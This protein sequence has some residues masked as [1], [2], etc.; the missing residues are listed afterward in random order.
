MI[1]VEKQEKFLRGQG[2][3][4]MRQ[5]EKIKSE[6]GSEKAQRSRNVSKMVDRKKKSETRCWRE[7]RLIRKD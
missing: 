7:I 5:V 2:L 3:Q 6:K 4:W 1:G